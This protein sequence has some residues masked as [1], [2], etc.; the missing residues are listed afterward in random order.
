MYLCKLLNLEP[1]FFGAV[2]TVVNMQPTIFLTVKSAKD[3][4]LVHLIGV[5]A[6]LA[7]GYLIG[8]S[9][10]I[11]GVVRIQLIEE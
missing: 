11:M 4:I 5:S 6:G 7:F 1:A 9:P 8:G 3:Q 2:A 10:L